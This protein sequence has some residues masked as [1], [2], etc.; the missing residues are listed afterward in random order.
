MNGIP[1]YAKMN[2]KMYYSKDYEG[3]IIDDYQNP[4]FPLNGWLKPCLICYNISSKYE[5]YKI[6]HTGEVLII[7]LC[8]LC[9]NKEKK[10]KYKYIAEQVDRVIISN[11][12]ED[13][14]TNEKKFKRVKERKR[15][16]SMS[17]KKDNIPTEIKSPDNKS[18]VCLII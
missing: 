11:Y 10:E 15:I 14:F 16:S 4:S 12:L 17:Q 6:L 5:K 7:N 1:K 9:Q 18:C 8:C 2:Y 3:Y 13:V